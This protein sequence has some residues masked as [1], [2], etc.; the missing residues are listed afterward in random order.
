MK[1]INTMPAQSISI[2]EVLDNPEG[3]SLVELIE[4][5]IGETEPGLI[6]MRGR[7]I[8]ELY[9]KFGY[10]YLMGKESVSK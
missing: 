7:Y 9:I 1:E 3:R 4:E 6:A 2:T 8:D 5:L 10:K